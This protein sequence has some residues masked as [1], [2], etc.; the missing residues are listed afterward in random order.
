[1]KENK[2]T[3]AELKKEYDTQVAQLPH[4]EYH[5]AHIL[6]PTQDAAAKIIAEL[7]K[8]AKFE[9]LAKKESTDSK[10]QGGDLGW[11]TA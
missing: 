9:D 10:D 5:V 8:G 3:E 2:P 6:V 11:M 1:M 7:N 4:T